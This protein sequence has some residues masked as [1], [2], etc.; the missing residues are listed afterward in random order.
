MIKN[1]IND[2]VIF[3]LIFFAW[4]IC[5][6]IKH[7]YK[8][9]MLSS[10]VEKI[11]Y[12]RKRNFFGMEISLGEH[13]VTYDEREAAKKILCCF[14]ENLEQSFWNDHLSINRKMSRMSNED[15][16]QLCFCIFLEENRFGVRLLQNNDNPFDCLVAICKPC[17]GGVFAKEDLYSCNSDESLYRFTSLGVVYYKLLYS[18]SLYC[19]HSKTIEYQLDS[20]L[21]KKFLDAGGIEHLDN[22]NTGFVWGGRNNMYVREIL[23]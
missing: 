11:K 20:T 13:R 21:I 17:I 12:C 23:K 22:G 4:A 18:T 16:F 7:L 3:I 5:I 9:A 1:L 6:E 15:F 19:E 10:L 8:C 14:R 2:T